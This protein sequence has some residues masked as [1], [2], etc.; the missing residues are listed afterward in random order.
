M[1]HVGPEKTAR[2]RAHGADLSGHSGVSVS[3]PGGV[4]G[5]S[6]GAAWPGAKARA[7]ELEVVRRTTLKGWSG[8]AR[9]PRS[10]EALKRCRWVKLRLQQSSRI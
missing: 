1:R 6:A 10:R 3:G 8:A 5:A 7:G 9:G 2:F 4:S